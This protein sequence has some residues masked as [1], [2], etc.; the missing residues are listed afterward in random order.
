MRRW[1]EMVDEDGPVGR[2]CCLQIT[3]E[4]KCRRQKGFSPSTSRAQNTVNSGFKRSKFLTLS[5]I[6]K[7]NYF[8]S[9]IFFF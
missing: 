5:T 6:K 9:S 1:R 4:L 3:E 7:W 8:I 2:M